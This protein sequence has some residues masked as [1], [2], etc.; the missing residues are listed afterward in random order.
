[1]IFSLLLSIQNAHAVEDIWPEIEFSE[2]T[3]KTPTDTAL[4]ISIEDYAFVS[5]IP[6]ANRNGQSWYRYF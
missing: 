1:M 5:D 4:I 2:E 6:G 3:Q